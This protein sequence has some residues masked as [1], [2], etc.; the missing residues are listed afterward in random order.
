MVLQEKCKYDRSKAKKKHLI[1]YKISFQYVIDMS[2][3]CHMQFK[4]D[5]KYIDILMFTKQISFRLVYTL[6]SGEPL[7]RG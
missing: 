6:L 2:L 4:K 1:T 3:L 5:S 7:L